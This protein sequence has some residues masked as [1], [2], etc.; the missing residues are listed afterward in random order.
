LSNVFVFWACVLVLLCCLMS[1][2]RPLVDV[3]ERA[4]GLQEG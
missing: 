3:V 1:Y 2:L 4:W